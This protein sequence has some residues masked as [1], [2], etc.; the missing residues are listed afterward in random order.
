MWCPVP[1]SS[2]I[3]KQLRFSTYSAIVNLWSPKSFLYTNLGVPL[4]LVDIRDATSIENALVQH[5]NRKIAPILLS[6]QCVYAHPLAAV[7]ARIYIPPVYVVYK[8][9]ASYRK[10]KNV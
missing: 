6:S 8:E 10:W 7:C 4:P 2:S 1:L 9:G 5:Q 3:I